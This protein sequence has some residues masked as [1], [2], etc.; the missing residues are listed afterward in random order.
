MKDKFLTGALVAGTLA[1]STILGATSASAATL[2]PCD[3]N[4]VSIAT[5]CQYV[6]PA[7]DSL[8]DRKN[9]NFVNDVDGLGLGFFDPGSDWIQNEDYFNTE[10]DLGSLITKAGTLSLSSIVFDSANISELMLLFK[11]GKG[12]TLTGFLAGNNLTAMFSYS[13]PWE[14]IF[15]K[16]KDISHI[17]VYYRE[18]ETPVVPTPA[19]VLPALFG[20]GVAAVRRKGKGSV[21]TEEA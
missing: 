18:G 10:F 4:L 5:A 8:N 17:S 20:M 21:A 15:G 11:D 12:S 9:P 16:A 1:V 6:D 3:K 7:T 19:V 14:S 13:E 2:K